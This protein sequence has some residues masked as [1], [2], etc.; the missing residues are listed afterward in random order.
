[1]TESTLCRHCIHLW[2]DIRRPRCTAFPNGIPMDVLYGEIL[3][4]YPLSDQENTIVFELDV[5]KL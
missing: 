4:T 3:H 2:D 5:E 1:M